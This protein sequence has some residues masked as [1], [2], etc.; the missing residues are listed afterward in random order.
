[1][2]VVRSLS[3]VAVVSPMHTVVHIVKVT[4]GVKNANE[5]CNFLNFS[6]MNMH[7]T[8]QSSKNLAVLTGHGQDGCNLLSRV[9]A[10][11]WV[12]S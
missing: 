12:S 9:E 1:M 8:N 10:H 5:W 7:M 3:I 2:V 11:R 4:D 6:Q